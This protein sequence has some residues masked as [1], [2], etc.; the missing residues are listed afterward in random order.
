MS[1][2][3][4]PTM[5]GL[6][7]LK[8]HVESD[9]KYARCWDYATS[10][11]NRRDIR[12]CQWDPAIFE[13][14]KEKM[15]SDMIV[16]MFLKDQIREKEFPEEI[17]TPEKAIQFIMDGD[18]QPTGKARELYDFLIMSILSRIDNHMNPA[19]VEN[20][21]ADRLHP[22]LKFKFKE[23]NALLDSSDIENPSRLKLIRNAYNLPQL[24]MEIFNDL[25]QTELMNYF[26]F[27]MRRI[28]VKQV[29][30]HVIKV[31]NKLLTTDY[32]EECD[33][34]LLLVSE[35]RSQKEH[36][37]SVRNETL[38]SVEAI[39]KE[40][41]EEEVT[42]VSPPPVMETKPAK[43]E[44]VHILSLNPDTEEEPEQKPEPETDPF[45][46]DV[47]EAE[48]EAAEAQQKAT[49]ELLKA[50]APASQNTEQ[51]LQALSEEDLPE[52]ASFD[53]KDFSD[54]GKINKNQIPTL[55][56]RAKIVLGT[57][58][59][60]VLVVLLILLARQ[61]N[62]KPDQPKKG[63]DLIADKSTLET[64]KSP[65]KIVKIPHQVIQAD[66][67]V[68]PP[69]PK[70]LIVPGPG[71]GPDP[72][73]PP[74]PDPN[75]VK[76]KKSNPY[77]KKISQLS[78]NDLPANYTEKFKSLFLGRK[79]DLKGDSM[80]KY[81]EDAIKEI[82]TRNQWRKFNRYLDGKM[83]PGWAMYMA[84]IN[85]AW[86]E[87]TY[88]KKYRRWYK[89]GHRDLRRYEK[90]K[91]RLASGKKLSKR[92]KRHL[93]YYEELMRVGRTIMLSLGAMNSG[94]DVNDIDQANFSNE[95]G[96]VASIVLEMAE[97]AGLQTPEVIIAEVAEPAPK[98]QL[99]EIT[100]EPTPD[101]EPTPNPEPEVDN[102]Q[103]DPV[104]A[105]QDLLQRVQHK[106][107]QQAIKNEEAGKV[108][109]SS[110]DKVLER[111]RK[112]REERR[113]KQEAKLKA[114]KAKQAAIAEAKGQVMEDAADR[115]LDRLSISKQLRESAEAKQPKTDN[116][117]YA[118]IEIERPPAK[119]EEIDPFDIAVKNAPAPVD[120]DEDYYDEMTLSYEDDDY[121]EVEIVKQD[122]EP[123]KGFFRRLFGRKAA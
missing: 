10:F 89:K 118:S 123:K 62:Q 84:S 99:A 110:A 65:E 8:R 87:D 5:N 83:K 19:E 13:E 27:F 4:R 3:K 68:P 114:E 22:Y 69:G 54:T 103:H 75:I 104:Q 29:Q 60:A 88:K 1:R 55:S 98:Q 71:P 32:K 108:M 45:E 33:A 17:D 15:L 112:R 66:A 82:A 81:V 57:V 35:K 43:Q 95:K 58:G 28:D 85:D 101:P 59:A 39:K 7:M 52:L 23:W 12:D 122:P 38:S 14:R 63:K 96:E 117:F 119:E 21:I 76:I 79:I 97:K 116:D 24:I 37:T 42:K 113:R 11:L 64:N 36:I 2:Q 61:Q 56:N 20:H 41:E 44:S 121:A 31:L 86:F 51:V 77:V 93:K 6:P 102:D 74:K 34:L 73:D 9:E 18:K 50:A 26:G 48:A 90:L 67:S 120:T 25:I 91:K 53:V 70:K 47:D 100:P 72:V 115:V 80:T 111:M 16:G 94:K 105:G 92:Q 40:T 49:E 107:A 109:V 46:V 106:E 30:P 78:L